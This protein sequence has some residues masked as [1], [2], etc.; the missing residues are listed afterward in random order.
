MEVCRPMDE[1][2]GEVEFLAK[3]GV[4][5]ITLLG[6][7][8]NGY[9]ASTMATVGGKTPFVQLLERLNEIPAL[10]RIRYM[11]P[12]PTYFSQDLIG[13]HGNLPKLCPSV[14][15]P[16]Q[17][18]SNRVLKSMGRPYGREKILAIVE[19]LRATV[20]EIGISTDIIVG[21]PG[22]TAE[23]F[24]ETLSLFDIIKFNMAFIFKYS[25]RSGTKSAE[26]A[27]DVPEMEKERRHKILLKRTE[28]ISLAYN[29]NFV[30]KTVSVLVEGHAKRGENTMFGWTPN[31]HKVLF[32]ATEG[33]IGKMVSVKINSFATTV[34]MG[35]LCRN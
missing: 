8:V 4:G 34:L 29:R 24:G 32:Q 25:P 35:T 11:S 30:G 21:Y 10:E 2:V 18:G 20:P 19:K 22:E 27:D 3:N 9:G 23:E 31:H 16:V 7:I 17:S 15:I 14:H 33:D 13:A 1:I 12:H 28:E 26:L 6:Q 5:E